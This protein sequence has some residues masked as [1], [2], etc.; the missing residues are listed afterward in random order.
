MRVEWKRLS[1]PISNNN[2]RWID[3]GTDSGVLVPHTG[4]IRT[5]SSLRY[6]VT[7][8]VQVQFKALYLR[9]GI[10]TTRQQLPPN[11]ES[12]TP[13]R[14]QHGGTASPHI[15]PAG[16][17]TRDAQSCISYSM[18]CTVHPRTTPP[19]PDCRLSHSITLSSAA[20]L[21]PPSRQA[22]PSPYPV[23]GQHVDS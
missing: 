6:V 10:L 16:Q 11:R 18:I 9:Q 17:R 2:A 5:C 13:T 8:V 7:R 15:V 3:A 22:S 19:S 21:P 23:S 4:D 12:C 1:R 14:Q 20:T